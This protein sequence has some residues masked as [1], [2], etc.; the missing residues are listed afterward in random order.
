MI[1][2][3]QRIMENALER[4]AATV[5]TY[6]PALLAAGTIFVGALLI[7]SVVRWALARVIKAT[8]IDRFLR[9][10]G[11]TSMLDR[12]GRL[13]ATRILA[14]SAYWGLLLVGLLTAL[15]AFDTSLT[16]RIVD[17][18]VRLLPKLVTAALILLAGAWLAQ[19]LG[20]S[21]LV[22]VCNEGIPYARRLAAATRIVVGFVSVV[23]AAD[24][25]DFARSVFL[26]A[27]VLLVGGAVLTVSIAVGIAAHRAL[28][29]RFSEGFSSDEK[30]ERPV[31][32]HL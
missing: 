22:W 12:S 31:W 27:F 28:A 16:S 17:S 29:H 10:S 2:A 8:A 32:N 19:Y 24:Y 15:S 9:Q 3:L 21:M 14:G 26:A 5:T 11:L 6:L 13:R 7:A 18:T 20:R 23:V 1:S 4:L 25:L 30:E